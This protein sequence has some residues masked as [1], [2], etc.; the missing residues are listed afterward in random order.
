VIAAMRRTLAKP[1]IAA[2]GR[3]ESSA[4]IGRPRDLLDPKLWRS[5]RKNRP[6]VWRRAGP[7]YVWKREAESHSICAYLMPTAPK[8]R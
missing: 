2:A 7:S 8:D 4:T 5:H 3:R 1:I 6:R